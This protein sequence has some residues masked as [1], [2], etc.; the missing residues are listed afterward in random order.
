V[1]EEDEETEAA[2]GIFSVLIATRYCYLFLLCFTTATIFYI[3]LITRNLPILSQT[4][5][6]LQFQP[7][8]FVLLSLSLPLSF[9]NDFLFTIFF[10]NLFLI[11][12]FFD[13]KLTA[14]VFNNRVVLTLMI[15][16][17]NILSLH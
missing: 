1:E 16:S 5:A 13:A 4:N 12:A 6:S 3:Y 10:N 14:N 17:Y 11:S 2:E 7:L 15:D 8:L 9:F